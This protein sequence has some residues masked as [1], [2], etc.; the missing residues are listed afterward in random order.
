MLWRGFDARTSKLAM[1]VIDDPPWEKFTMQL[2]LAPKR[3]AMRATSGNAACTR[4][5][6]LSSQLHEAVLDGDE[7][8]ITRLMSELL[9]VRGLTK[10]QRV[11]LQMRALQDMVHSLRASVVSDE[12]TG[13]PNRRGFMQTAN[14]LLDLAARDGRAAH[15]V[16]FRIEK[17]A[18]G[19]SA[20]VCVRQIGN[21]LRD[22]FP[23]YGVYDVIGRLSDTEF[24][25][26]T[27]DPELVARTEVA[28]QLRRRELSY[29]AP[30]LPL[31]IGVAHFNPARP[32]TIDELLQSALR[33]T[34][35]RVSA[36]ERAPADVARI[37]S[38]GFAP[39]PGM[40][41]C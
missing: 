1:R 40:T 20:N 5:L 37:A 8:R 16:Y 41:L 6:E 17:L 9:R 14:R 23:G 32:I 30:P 11:A 33:L 15:V 4:A 10:G 29:E 2:A 34:D 25:A 28:L 3:S 35:A 7:K 19:E 21:L 36:E 31:A 22:L 13:L 39:H 24:A 38:S 27:T 18:G 12:V 26:L